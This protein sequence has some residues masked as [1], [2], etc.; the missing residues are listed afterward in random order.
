MSE[1]VVNV[2]AELVEAIAQRAAEIVL[3]RGAADPA[4]PYMTVPE[5]AEYLRCSRARVDNLRSARKLTP[6][7]EGGR[8]VCLRS[9]VEALAAVDGVAQLLPMHGNRRRSRGSAA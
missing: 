1:V 6:V 3:E 7:K 2:P 5:A 4:S 8:A 9:E